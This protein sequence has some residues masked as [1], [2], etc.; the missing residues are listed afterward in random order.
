MSNYWGKEYSLWSAV[1]LVWSAV[2]K[3]KSKQLQGFDTVKIA[4]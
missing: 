1:S 4:K 3:K 2:F